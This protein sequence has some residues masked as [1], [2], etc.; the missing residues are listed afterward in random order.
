MQILVDAYKRSK[1]AFSETEADNILWSALE[2]GLASALRGAKELVIVVDGGDESSC[3]APALLQRLVSA[4][5]AGT[6]VKLVALGFDKH[7]T[8]ENQSNFQITDDLIFD[9]IA[10]ITRNRFKMNRSFRE[11]P[12]IDQET[13]VDRVTD[14]SNG[15]YMWAKL[16]GKQAGLENTADNFRKT[17]GT[18]V[19]SKPSITDLIYRNI[20]SSEVTDDARAILLWLSTAE[21][22]LLLAEL[23][24]LAS[25]Q[26]EN[27]TVTD[28]H[29]DLLQALKP[30]NSLVFLQNS[31]VYL[32]H[33]LIRT[34]ILDIFSKGKL[35]PTIKDRHYD[36]TMRLL[37]YIKSTITEQREPSITP[38]DSHDTYMLVNKYPLL[39]FAARYW[40]F[41][42]THTPVFSKGVDTNGA[43]ELGK[44]FPTS[45]TVLLLQKTLWEKLST[46]VI[47]A[48]QTA[49][50]DLCRH[51]FTPNHVMTLQSII[52]LAYLYRDVNHVPEAIP[53]F[54]EATVIS[55]TLLTT[56]HIVTIQ[57]ANAFLD[58]TV[59]RVTTTKTD[60]MVRREEVLV[61][62]V[63]CYKIHYGANSENV[64]STLKQLVE[65]YHMVKEEHKVQEIITSIQTLTNNGYGSDLYDT[66]SDLSVRLRGRKTDGADTGI[67]LR[68]DVEEHDELLEKS[69]TYDFDS[70]VEQAKKYSA[71]GRLQHA[72]RLYVEIWQRVSREFRT[73]QSALW[74][75]RKLKAILVY[76]QYL[77]SQ[78][79][80]QE[81]SSILSSAWA[82][83]L[84]SSQSLSETSVS[85][86]KE[87][88]HVMQ[89]VGLSAVALSVFKACSHFY[90]SNNSTHS[91][92]YSDIQKS[93]Q[94]TSQQVM[95]QASSSSSSVSES[96]LEEMVV[97]ASN[98]TSIDQS[99]ISATHSLV[100]LYVSQH[101]W[102][103]A[104]RV[105]KKVLHGLW[106]SLFAPSIQD[107]TFPTKHVDDSLYLA[108][109]LSQCYHYR[110]RFAKEEG[111]RVRVYRAVRWAKPVDDKLRDRVTIDLLRFYERTFQTEKIITIRQE[112]LH[113]YIS[114]YGSE[115]PIVIRTL[116]TLAKLTRP[117]PIF[118]E[119][120][121]QIIQ[122]L[123]KDSP[124]SHPDAFEPLVVVAIELWSQGRYSDAVPYFRVIFTTFL[125]QPKQSPKLQDASFV[126]DIFLN[127]THCLRSISA[128]FSILH[129]ITVEYQTNSKT[130][131]GATSTI[132]VQATLT[133]A[134]LCQESQ[135]YEHEAINLY[136]ELLHTKSEEVD[137]EE[138]S[139]ILD[140]I[141]EE[142]TLV[143]SR[144]ES[145]SSSQAQRAVKVLKKRLSSVRE[146]HG[147]AHEESLS[148]L[149]K[150]VSFHHKRNETETVV[151][152]LKEAAVH[153]ISSESSST[154]LFASAS[155]I[156]ASYIESN[157]VHK[158][159]ELTQE[160]YRQI[161]MKETENSKSV[162]FDLSSTGR[163]SLSFLAQLEHSLRPSSSSVTEI[164]AALT[165][166]F[167]Y[168][169]DFR[170]VIHAKSSTI[171]SVSISAARLYQFLLSSNR[172]T[173]ASRVFDEFVKYFGA[174]EGK[175]VRLTDSAQ[176]HIFLLAILEHFSAHQSQNFVR[177]VGIA[178]NE[179]VIRLLNAKQY[180]SAANLAL[181]SFK[182]I[183]SHD[184]YRTPG[185]I[186]FALNLGMLI[187]GRGLNPQPDQTS[188]Q[189]MLDVSA[190]IVQ[191]ALQVVGELKINLA[192]IG[193]VHL[194]S[195][196]SILGEKQDYK[197]LAWLL[198]E[199]W[200]NH[201][202]Q[203]NWQ[204]YVTLALGRRFILARYLIGDSI[205]AI[206]LAEDIVYNCRRV[207][208]VRHDSTLG[209]SILLSQ[210]Y[211]G[212]AQRYQAHKDGQDMAN[213]YYKKSAAVHENIVRVLTD[214]T[215]AEFQGGLDAS[216]SMDGSTYD[217]GL[218]ETV[219]GMAKDGEHVRQHM[220][221][222]KL[223]VQRIG[224]W[225]KNYGEYERLS[226][227][228]FREFGADLKGVEGV[229]KWNLKAFG[230]GKAQ[231][232]EDLL[233]LSFNNW[234]LVDT[235]QGADPVEEE[236]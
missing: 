20:Q 62:L 132:A 161:V 153:I 8:A 155:T 117:R 223:A 195:L 230:S 150:M 216:I 167:V 55:R 66:Q 227:D 180:D 39:E 63:E 49:V 136:E 192:Q 145:V 105:V 21:R 196:I 13:L 110:H 204:P 36:L 89:A 98:S 169:E 183:S 3:G 233:D 205:A 235:Q 185:I 221:L 108:D 104:T 71:E 166:Q 222:L 146:S 140:G 65:F 72:E 61:L 78:K 97:E 81:A 131:F 143:S 236:L 188:H 199:L 156:A 100:G 177:S 5:N 137:A 115:H 73:H 163:Q 116:W 35:I 212:V 9:D 154:R 184:E 111:I 193:L 32:R 202:A 41:H 64:V 134:K 75:E 170:S 86:F 186:K 1:A 194:N 80:Q 179:H 85:Q 30:L 4:A 162:N 91:S 96:T 88:A 67:G 207:H 121:Q 171:H 220:H 84:E 29:V 152:Q 27:Y 203:R 68:L 24:T 57:M 128:D 174:T 6:N 60:L 76:S 46:P 99:S 69:E 139:S 127:Y 107:V 58:L 17:V 213:R 48:Y 7:P 23:E 11:M 232:N 228:V 15:S 106:P 158:A 129:K 114:H 160:L 229:D 189:K 25:I 53:L 197:S 103:N 16:A 79:R 178:G 70:Q 40:P 159:T 43:K 225:P 164:L 125:E 51:I 119:Y 12:E 52:S 122:A 210:L 54:H 112:L 56:R 82:E 138:I 231:G 74:E 172:Q 45:P 31:Q 157:Q 101:R 215:Y 94:S 123:N 87:I 83:H 10:T 187:S 28:R 26:V 135:R 142:E 219:N 38:F 190:A 224:D 102:K 168:F 90:Q 176:V 50:T 234:E 149:R 126:R 200:N 19:S 37:I 18:V 14:A 93:I 208:G 181:A 217:L 148:D 206:R 77:H 44:V 218:D 165:T 118:I 211:T 209:T 201:E 92:S 133:L 42:L 113:D 95:H 22:P 198:T 214:P 151:Q 59:D 34:A 147:W 144:S 33:G 173:A 182:F 141:Y 120:Y 191:H 226:S 47:L 109:R 175:R 124:V 2:R 130:V